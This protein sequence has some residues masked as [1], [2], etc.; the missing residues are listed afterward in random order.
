MIHL[1]IDH[2]PVEATEDMTI[3]EAATSIGI[4][5]PT[6]CH[7]DLKELHCI[8]SPGACRI[9]VVEVEGRRNLA[10]SCRTKCTEGMVVSTHTQRV[11]NARRTVME[12]I[13]SDH[14]KDCLTCS[15]N[16]NCELQ[17]AAKVV[18]IHEIRYVGEES[19]HLPDVSISIIRDMDK[20]IMC[21]RCE[22][23]CNTVQSVG[24]LT[25]I[26][27][28]FGAV[29]GTA[30]NREIRLSNCTNCGQCI[31]ICPTG[32]LSEHPNINEV[33]QA[34]FNPK[35]TVVVQTA[36]AVR[37]ALGNDYGYEPGHDVTGKMISALRQLG[38]DYVFDTNFAADVT[39]MEEG[40]ELLGRLKNFIA[41]QPTVLPMTT[42]CCPAWVNFME[43]NYPKLL[44]HLSTVRSPQQIFGSIAKNY[45]GPMKH[46]KREDMVVVS[47]M[48]CVAKKQECTRE[49]FAVD[50]HP[51]VDFSLTTRELAHFIQYNNI[52]F[53]HLEDDSFDSPLGESTGAGAIFGTTGGVI[54]AG[55]R[56][57]YEIMM[58][59]ALPRIDFQELRGFQ[60]IRTATIYFG[61]Q[62]L[63]LAIAHGLSNARELI[64]EVEAGKSP[65]HAIEV[66]ACPGGC[67]GGG[68]QPFHHGDI[69]VIRQRQEALYKIDRDKP[70][71]KSHENPGVI[72]LYKNYYNHHNSAQAH[73]ELH[74]HY[75]DRKSKITALKD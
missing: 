71:R 48:P 37:V 1:I 72:S 65:Y 7:L 17:T 6:L 20:C 42:S 9:C 15:K 36:P 63:H 74:T 60:G 23:V 21:R 25:A 5:I 53:R 32:A 34:I 62:P 68:G 22:T 35:K 51:D 38:F 45:F 70:L 47:I 58:G 66:M 43:M 27:R 19:H 8:N 44:P 67:I 56:T 41:G 16:G 54:E 46:I 30:F 11:L 52:D 31:A 57:A 12:L 4:T 73:H 13:L 69:Q 75:T 28:G 14:P 55:T 40:T 10:P 26:N 64:Q 61:E 18:G 33:Q 29:V 3:L 49:E 39:I 24:A 50:G 59:E 2:K